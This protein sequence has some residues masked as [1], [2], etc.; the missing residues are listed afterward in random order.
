[1]SSRCTLAEGNPL[2][3][4]YWL[5]GCV[6]G[7]TAATLCKEPGVTVFGVC[8]LCD[9]VWVTQRSRTKRSAGVQLFGRHSKYFVLR[10]I[11]LLIVVSK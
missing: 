3:S 1:M 10:I 2:T 6:L 4:A 7:G 9:A 5:V 11:F 8:M